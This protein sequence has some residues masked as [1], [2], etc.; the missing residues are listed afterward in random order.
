VVRRAVPCVQGARGVDSR[1]AGLVLRGVRVG[2][3]GSSVRSTR[4][5]QSA[6]PLE[7]VRDK[8]DVMTTVYKIPHPLGTRSRERAGHWE[9]YQRERDARPWLAERQDRHS[10]EKDRTLQGLAE[11]DRLVGGKPLSGGTALEDYPTLRPLRNRVWARRRP[12]HAEA[13][14]AGLVVPELVDRPSGQQAGCLYDVLRVGPGVT[15]VK[16]GDCV[17]VHYAVAR[18][19]GDVLG[20][21]VY[22]FVADVD[23]VEPREYE[24][25][26]QRYEDGSS[27]TF[28]RRMSDTERRGGGD[29]LGLAVDSA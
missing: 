22:Q 3:R 9:E 11:I 17:A 10:Y 19:L 4:G 5:R 26:R 15:S 1:Q 2:L 21:G 12:L 13:K 6:A 23:Y 20:E 14:A 25:E 18:D 28:E 27:T 8:G 7:G 16:P 29:V 24:T